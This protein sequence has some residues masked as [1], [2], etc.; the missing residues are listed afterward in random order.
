MCFCTGGSGGGP[1][2]LAS[3]GCRLIIG[4]AGGGSRGASLGDTLGESLG[5]SL[6]AKTLEI[7]DAIFPSVLGSL[8]FSGDVCIGS[9]GTC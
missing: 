9:L 7:A 5:L 4:L 1:L 8:T 3:L 2:A 6:A